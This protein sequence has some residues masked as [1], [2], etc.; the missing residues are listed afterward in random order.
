MIRMK[1]KLL[2]TLV[3]LL[4]IIFGTW[5]YLANKFVTQFNEVIAAQINDNNS[6]ITADLDSIIIDKFK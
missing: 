5:Y 6:F 2:S 1:K 3:I 4:L